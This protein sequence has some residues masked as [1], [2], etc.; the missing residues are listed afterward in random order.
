ML[1][2]C[3]WVISVFTGEGFN[4]HRHLRLSFMFYQLS[5]L[6]KPIFP[7]LLSQPEPFLSHN[8]PISL[9]LSGDQR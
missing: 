5:C 4:A 9:F 6:V 1:K 3:V 7:S 8:L 2:F